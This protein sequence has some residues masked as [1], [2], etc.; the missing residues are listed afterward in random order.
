MT[1]RVDR[2]PSL[3]RGFAVG[4]LIGLAMLGILLMI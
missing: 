4:I 3:W 2:N 1:P